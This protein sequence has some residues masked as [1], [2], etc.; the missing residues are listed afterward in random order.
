MKKFL[1]ILLV[2]SM[3]ITSTV[4]S[5][6]TTAD[7]NKINLQDG[8]PSKFQKF[9][10]VI[11]ED[12]EKLDFLGIPAVMLTVAKVDTNSNGV[13]NMSLGDDRYCQ[14]KIQT[15]KSGEIKLDFY[16]D[17]IHNELI[18][19]QDGTMI[20][21]GGK[22]T[23]ESENLDSQ[24]MALVPYAYS[25][26]YSKTPLKGKASDYGLLIDDYV[27]N[28]IGL[29]GSTLASIGSGALATI[30]TNALKVTLAVNVYA[31]IL[32]TLATSMI[33][34]AKEQNVDFSYASYHMYKYA[35]LDNASYSQHYRYR[36]LY[37]AGK[38]CS[39]YT[40]EDTFYE[41]KYFN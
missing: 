21:D 8:I 27:H 11:N 29:G 22:V 37:Y 23:I 1:S 33:L 4:A 15:L 28:S 25:S 20:L 6:A 41:Y 39:R 36:G 24:K 18:F 40:D 10:D 38:N 3:L 5:F 13:Y 31:G 19:L 12:I 34:Y 7:G 35:R 26:H 30:L 17:G 14:V 2:L 9:T 16:E 32:T